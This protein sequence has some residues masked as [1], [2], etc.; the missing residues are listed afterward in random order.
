[1]IWRL[2]WETL[3]TYQLCKGD[4]T[5]IWGYCKLEAAVIHWLRWTQIVLNIKRGV[6]WKHVTA[7][8][9]AAAHCTGALESLRALTVYYTE[10]TPIVFILVLM[11]TLTRWSLSVCISWTIV[12]S[13][14]F[15]QIRVQGY[16]CQ[17]DFRSFLSFSMRKN[18]PG[19]WILCIIYV[20]C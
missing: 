11:S 20:I 10:I 4:Y 17:R 2:V 15:S 1:M 9:V 18:A 14:L 19:S 16:W 7:P 5:G 3:L 8:T 13:I 6:F 12:I